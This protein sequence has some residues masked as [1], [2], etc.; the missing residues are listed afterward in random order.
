VTENESFKQNSVLFSSHSMW[1]SRRPRKFLIS[2]IP[3]EP[4]QN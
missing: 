1:T 4:T 2:W 3:P